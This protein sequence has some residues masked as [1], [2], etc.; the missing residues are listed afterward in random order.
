MAPR[1]HRNLLWLHGA[2]AEIDLLVRDPQ[3]VVYLIARPEPGLAAFLTPAADKV[4]AR[5]LK[6]GRPPRRVDA[7]R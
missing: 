3:L 6:L 4:A 7:P 1:V 5:L 2:A